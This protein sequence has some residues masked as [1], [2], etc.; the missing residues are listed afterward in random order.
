MVNPAESGFR[1]DQEN[2]E[3]EQRKDKKPNGIKVIKKLPIGSLKIEDDPEGKQKKE[4][5]ERERKEKEKRDRESLRDY[6]AEWKLAVKEKQ[7]NPYK[8]LD[9]LGKIF[10]GDKK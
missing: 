8:D 9:D 4:R 5:E 3:T 10:P 6:A 7:D 2:S 1:P